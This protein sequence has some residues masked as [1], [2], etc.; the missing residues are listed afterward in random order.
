LTQAVDA[1]EHKFRTV[2]NGLDTLTDTHRAS[3]AA[4]QML[5]TLASIRSTG[6]A[7]S[8]SL[9]REEQM[10][11][12]I[13]RQLHLPEEMLRTRLTAMRRDAGRRRTTSTQ[14]AVP[15]Y[16]QTSSPVPKLANCRS[17]TATCWNL[18]Y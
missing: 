6:G 7:T 9:I 14:S 17:R 16:I 11:S 5:A 13:A 18:C 8:Q 1:L 3:Q 2:T 15:T 12:R 4:E 10:L